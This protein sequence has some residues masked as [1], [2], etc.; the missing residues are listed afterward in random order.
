M[1]FLKEQSIRDI[2]VVHVIFAVLAAAVV[3][4]PLGTEAGW[5]LLLLVI[6]YNV[7]IPAVGYMRGHLEWLGIWLFV[8]LISIMQVVPDW[9]L[10]A[11][12]DVLAFPVDGSP[13]IGTVPLYMAGLWSI[14]LF[15]LVYIGCRIEE[16]KSQV[17]ALA[18]V[19]LLSLVVFTLAEETMWMLPSWHAQNVATIG[20]V[21]LYIIVPE[22]LLGASAYILYALIRESAHWRK[23]F[24]AY[25]VMVIYL[26]NVAL[27]YFLV[28]RI[29]LGT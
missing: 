2:I 24:W 28:Q 6:A 20:H 10:S 17:L 14:P 19:M 7:M 26:G 21:A 13:T 4:L 18:A 1:S 11:Q 23:V 9:F 16:K 25:V 12:L 27:F 8:F 3:S 5:K 22:I 15:V 29:L